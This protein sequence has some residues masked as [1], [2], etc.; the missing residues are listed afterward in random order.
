MDVL[1]TLDYEMC[2]GL[3]SGTVQ[4]CLITPTEELL[5]II[6]KYN[7]KATFFIDT[8]FLIRLR[9]LKDNHVELE[10][11]WNLITQQI[12]KLAT[13]GHDI[14][15]H[16][17][18]NWYNATYVGGRWNSVMDDYKL[19]DMTS[20][21]VD[22]MFSQGIKL[23]ESLTKKKVVAFRAGAY[24]IQT[25]KNYPDLYRKYGIKI[26]S[27]VNRYHSVKTEKWEWFDYTTI[28]SKYQYFFS[29]DVCVEDSNGDLIEVSIP[30][31]RISFL[32]K[33]VS[34][35]KMS[36]ITLSR[37]PWGDGKASVGGALYSCFKKRWVRFIAHL[38]PIY[39]V[40]SIDSVGS[41]YLDSIYMKEKKA[42]N[43]LL[44]MGHP[45]CFTPFSLRYFEKFL[46]ERSS[47]FTNIAINTFL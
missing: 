23:L 36:K 45:K 34:R 22:S 38:K 12:S 8:C 44:I 46:N 41:Y 37:K 40:A 9:Q 13:E 2:N 42:G 17:H 21:E 16:L 24:C 11:D 3:D 4:N 33:Y 25:L 27:S 28:P 26:D 39:I 15:L 30:S 18:P 35:Y 14:E 19:S 6:D 1:L 47:E 5:K 7:F 20:E 31:H 29:S 43:Y 10:R 32:K